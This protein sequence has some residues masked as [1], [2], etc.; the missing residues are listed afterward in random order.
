MNL[1]KYLITDPEFYGTTTKDFK[2]NLE[3]ILSKNEINFICFRD[4]TSQ[5]YKELIKVF[6]EVCSAKNIENIFINSYINEAIKYNVGVHLTS[7]QFDEI[8]TCKEQNLQVI[9]SC[10]NQEDINKAK[11]DGA[12]FITYSPIFESPGKKDLKGIENLKQIVQSNKDIKIFALGGIVTNEHIKQIQTT[13]CFGFAS[14]RYF[15]N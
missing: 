11:N 14:I 15:I 8:K 4:K 1:Q 3:K 6:I 7:T 12:D 2:A 10:H 9:V 13:N 5:N